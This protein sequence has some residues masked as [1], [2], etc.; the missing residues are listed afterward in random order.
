MNPT[1]FIS[2][3]LRLVFSL[4]LLS[5]VAQPVM[6]IAN[7][8]PL[9]LVIP[10]RDVAT[11][12]DINYF[13]PLLKLALSKTED[14]DGPYQVDF[15]PRQ[16]SSARILSL[17]ENNEG[18]DLARTSTSSQ[19]ERDLGYVPVSLLGQLSDYRVLMI[20]A[21]DQARF[22]HV[23]NLADLQQMRMGIGGHWPDARLLANNG[24]MTVT[25]IY[26][27]SLFN[28][29]A[30]KRFEAFPRGLFEAWDDLAAHPNRGLAVEQRLMLHYP[31][32]FYFFVNKDNT[33]LAERLER[34]LKIAQ[35]DGS[36]DELMM[37]IPAFRQGLDELNRGQRLVF[38]L[39]PKY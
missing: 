13:Y 3:H 27:E 20:R 5:W 18:I 31:A 14:T 6:A 37:S 33:A 7:V 12:A 23:E 16:L 8:Q 25:S 21:R 17:I 15:Y 35:A 22:N 1:A 10:T 28:M 39:E 11:T 4:L 2:R 34:G 29:L 32:P 26:Y 24:F 19:R 30:V 36:F 9:K 38:E